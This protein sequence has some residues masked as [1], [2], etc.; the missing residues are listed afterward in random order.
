MKLDLSEYRISLIVC[1]VDMRRGFRSLSILAQ[2]L[3]NVDVAGGRDCVVFISSRRTVCKLIWSDAHGS[4]MITRSLSRSR[5][6]RL[7]EIDTPV[8][9]IPVS[10]L[11]RFL[12]G[13]QIER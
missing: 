11:L 2:A 6:C 8:R 4:S 12:D 9:L 5:F 7:F 13:E 1:P 3:I 10:E